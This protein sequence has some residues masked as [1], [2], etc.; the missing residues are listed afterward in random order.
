MTDK[1][2]KEGWM[3]VPQGQGIR[4]SHRDF[5]LRAGAGLWGGAT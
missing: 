1:S 3:M 4:L 2:L 5:I